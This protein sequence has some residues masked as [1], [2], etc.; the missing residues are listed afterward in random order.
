M[1]IIRGPLAHT[2]VSIV[3]VRLTSSYR[4]GQRP[5]NSWRG[6]QHRAIGAL[7]VAPRLQQL[8]DEAGPA[9]LMAGA[10]AVAIVAVE[11]LVEE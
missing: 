7:A 2:S 11:V 10:E 6:A 9:G 1:L 5:A 8:G 4:A 3:K